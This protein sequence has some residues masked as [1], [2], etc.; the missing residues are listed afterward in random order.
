VTPPDDPRRPPTLAGGAP[1][2][3]PDAARA[4]SARLPPRDT[5]DAVRDAIRDLERDV[6]RLGE[7]VTNDLG[8]LVERLDLRLGSGSDTMT[9]LD[10]RVGVVERAAAAAAEVARQASAPARVPWLRVI[11]IVLSALVLAATVVV[12]MDRKVG[13]GDLDAVIRES[14]ARAT[15]AEARLAS[16][17]VAL[18]E[19]RSEDTTLRAVIAAVDLAIKREARAAPRRTPP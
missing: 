3:P 15:V 5:Q 8:R 4:G 9:R 6:E 14:T 19:A 13:R 12:T 16:L 10:E 7:R 1:T 2:R 18:A 11:P 17:E